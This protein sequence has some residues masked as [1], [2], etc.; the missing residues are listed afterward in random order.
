MLEGTVAHE[1]GMHAKHCW[2]RALIGCLGGSLEHAHILL[3]GNNSPANCLGGG[4][5]LNLGALLWAHP[6][7]I[8]RVDCL[9]IG[10]GWQ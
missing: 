1:P 5:M 3:L 9:Y 8:S 2:L 4:R 6:G 10:T 7:E